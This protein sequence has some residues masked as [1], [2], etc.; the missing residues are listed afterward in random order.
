MDIRT[1]TQNKATWRKETMNKKNDIHIIREI[2]EFLVSINL[3]NKEV[4]A[5]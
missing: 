5:I 4:I 1:D 2:R 3:R